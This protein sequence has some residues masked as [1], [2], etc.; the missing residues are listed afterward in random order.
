[1]SIK[2]VHCRCARLELLSRLARK[3]QHHDP[4][5][6]ERRRHGHGAQGDSVRL[7]GPAAGDDRQRRAARV[8]P[9]SHL[10]KR[11][12]HG[13]GSRAREKKQNKTKKSITAWRGKKKALVNAGLDETMFNLI[14]WIDW[15]DRNFRRYSVAAETI[16]LPR[17]KRQSTS[18]SDSDSKAGARFFNSLFFHFYFYIPFRKIAEANQNARNARQ[19]W[20]FNNQSKAM[21][22]SVGSAI[23]E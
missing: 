12:R 17:K 16:E 4:L 11:R 8:V 13:C 9:R 15:S 3:R 19:N 6:V 21:Q 14:G 5:R 2:N 23:M 7:P 20:Q 10:R 22:K 18:C 1:L